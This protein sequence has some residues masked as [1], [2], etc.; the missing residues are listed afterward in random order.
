MEAK[1]EASLL[2]QARE[3]AA[4]AAAAGGATCSVG[5]ECVFYLPAPRGLVEGHI[6]STTGRNEFKISG[7][8]E[9]HFDQ[10]MQPPLDISDPSY[11]ALRWLMGEKDHVLYEAVLGNEGY[12]DGYPRGE[13]FS[14]DLANLVSSELKDER[15]T[16]TVALDLDIPARL[17]PS[18]T[19]GHSH[20]FIDIELDW[21][22][23]E[24]L[25]KA[26]AEAGI[27]ESGYVAVSI[28]R[29]A[30]HLRLPWIRKEPHDATREDDDK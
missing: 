27:I 21:P 2:Q 3:T 26:L 12:E 25:L 1:L 9:Y 29:Q 30:T 19:P 18:S 22:K 4:A 23:Y 10:I 8:C 17:V 20:L 13:V 6:Y 28:E 7:C 16:H 24:R 11:Q 14:L 5:G 15:G